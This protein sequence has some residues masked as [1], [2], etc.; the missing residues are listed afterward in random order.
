MDSAKADTEAN[1]LTVVGKVDP[2]MLRDKLAQKTKKKVDLL[3]PQP[4]K[5]NKT[6]DKSDEKLEKKGGDKKPKEVL[7]LVPAIVRLK[8]F[9]FF[10]KRHCHILLQLLSLLDACALVFR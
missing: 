2:T 7:S 5:D 3:S 8:F 4:K 1:K 9:F 10:D 6:D